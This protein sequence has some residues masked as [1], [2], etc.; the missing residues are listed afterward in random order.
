MLFSDK[1]SISP[2]VLKE[3][4]A[5][6]ISLVCDTPLFIDP[7]LIYD[8]DSC[9]IKSWYPKIVKYLLFLNKIANSDIRKDKIKYYF[10]FKEIKENWLGVAKKG[11]VGS[12]LGMDFAIELYKNINTVC[13][14]NSCSLDIH[15]EKM[16]L[17]NPGVGKDKISDMVTNILFYEF[18]KYTEEFSRKYLD[19]S[20]CSL[21]NIPK[22]EFDYEKELFVDKKAFLPYIINSKGKKEFI[23]LTPLSILRKDEQEINYSNMHDSFDEVCST[24]SN[25]DLRF[26]VNSLIENTIK[27]MYNAKMSIQAIVTQADINKS[28]SEAIQTAV[29]KFPELFD[30]FIKLEEQKTDTVK[31]KAS[32]EVKEIAYFTYENEMLS[33]DLFRID[34]KQQYTSSFEE[35]MARI[36]FLKKEI[37]VNSLWK[38]LYYE[39]KPIT[40]E[41]ELQRLFR[42]C[43][44]NSIRRCSPETNNGKGPVDF[45]ISY[46]FKDTC[47]IEFKLA[48]NPK[49]KNVFKQLSAYNESQ[50]VNYSIVVIFYFNDLEYS[51][52]NMI[53]E[54]GLKRSIPVILINCMRNSISAS[55]EK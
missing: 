17:V 22:C 9:E 28:K 8:N 54:D 38:N 33:Y 4:G 14:T 12:A 40:H 5:V 52:A 16:L 11:N 27:E 23:I 20:L 34:N 32:K 36:N 2:Q 51:K 25:D 48:S 3:Y 15:I 21:F 19:D 30:Y 50:M 24:I 43:W 45:Q 35:A 44:F 31:Q 29:K 53:Y 46:G 13:E 37:E 47:N 6:N 55:N 49:L 26:Q 39:D 18:I 42:L 41:A 1:F 7:L 10:C